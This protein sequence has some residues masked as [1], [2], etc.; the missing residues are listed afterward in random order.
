MTPSFSFSF[1]LIIIIFFFFFYK[2]LYINVHLES[3][4]VLFQADFPPFPCTFYSFFCEN[5]VQISYVCQILELTILE[6]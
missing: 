6:V 4:T 1:S 2:V 3:N 5:I